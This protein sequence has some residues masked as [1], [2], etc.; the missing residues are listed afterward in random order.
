MGIC[1]LQFTACQEKEYESDGGKQEERGRP[2]YAEGMG[3]PEWTFRVGEGL[4]E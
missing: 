3:L 4:L 2:E 1:V